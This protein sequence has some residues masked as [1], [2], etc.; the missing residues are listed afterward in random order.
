VALA[1]LASPSITPVPALAG[2]DPDAQKAADAAASRY[3]DAQV[4]VGELD[5]EIRQLEQQITAAGSRSPRSKA[6]RCAAP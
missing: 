1:V 5:A 2:P 6:L 3:E 4:R